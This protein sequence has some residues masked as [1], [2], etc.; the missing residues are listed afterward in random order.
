MIS[1]SNVSEAARM[2]PK[3]GRISSVRSR[4]RWLTFPPAQAANQSSRNENTKISVGKFK[5]SVT[6]ASHH[7]A[8]RVPRARTARRDKE[9]TEENAALHIPGR[10]LIRLRRPLHRFPK[11]PKQQ[12]QHSQRRRS[13]KS[14]LERRHRKPRHKLAREP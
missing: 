4:R 5:G 6:L 11:E 8:Q 7:T 2:T 14:R 12:M 13:K 3:S 1:P 9:N 10:P